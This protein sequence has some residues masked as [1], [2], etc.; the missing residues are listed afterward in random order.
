M[1]SWWIYLGGRIEEAGEAGRVVESARERI[2]ACL[3]VWRA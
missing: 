2:V 3:G 1:T